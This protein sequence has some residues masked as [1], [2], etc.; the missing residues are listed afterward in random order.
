MEKIKKKRIREKPGQVFRIPL[1]KGLFGY[2]QFVDPYSVFFDYT[3][4][5]IDTDTKQVV[6]QPVIFTVTVDDYVIKDQFWQVIAV[7]PVNPAFIKKREL[8]SYSRDINGYLIWKSVTQQIIA[9]PDEIKG[10][11][12]FSSWGHRHVEQRLLDYFEGRPNYSYEVQHNL[13]NPDFPKGRIAFYNQYNYTM[14]ED[15][16]GYKDEE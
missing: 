3:D 16:P 1:G 10:M 11:E 12:C 14:K 9:T 7:L 15:E 5:G 8:F 4:G 2:G 13:H 6:E